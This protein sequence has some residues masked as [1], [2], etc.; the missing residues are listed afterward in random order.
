MKEK[1]WSAEQAGL[2]LVIAGMI[3]LCLQL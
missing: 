3:V 2:L 1:L